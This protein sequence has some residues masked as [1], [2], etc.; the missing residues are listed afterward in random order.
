MG[1]RPLASV[2]GRVP[3][4]FVSAPRPRPLVLEGSVR[5]LTLALAEYKSATMTFA[6]RTTSAIVEAGHVPGRN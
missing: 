1:R 3:D 5:A 4:A 6:S 2:P